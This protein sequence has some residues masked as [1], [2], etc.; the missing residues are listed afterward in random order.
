MFDLPSFQSGFAAFW[1]DARQ[2]VTAVRFARP[3]WLWLSVVPIALS[4][5]AFVAARYSRRSLA[6]LGR[7]SA[8]FALL[9]RPR[10]GRY[11]RSILLVIVWLMLVV[12]AAGP[13]WGRGADDGVAVGRDLVLVIDLSR[14]MLAEDASGPARW[15]SAVAAASDI[16]ASLRT[17]G[18]HR[19]AVVVF[20]ARPKLLVPLTT[21][22]DHL[23]N[24]I[25]ELDGKTL[26]PD[27]R[28]TAEAK[29]GTRI[30]AAIIAAVDAHDVRFPGSQDILLFSDGDDPVDDRE[31]ASGINAARQA[32]IPV[33]AIGIGD[34]DRM[35]PVT[36]N[37]QLLEYATKPGIPDPVQTRLHEEVLRAIADESRGYYVPVRREVPQLAEFFRTKIE[38]F[39]SR[40]LTDDALP[41][42]RDRAAWFLGIGVLFLVVGWLRER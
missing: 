39:P 12:G 11:F 2:F 1:V 31:W 41:Q 16:V 14:S 8:I 28:P 33:H 13:R 10:A 15:E 7:P 26:L 37:G 4:I 40:E 29:S 34:P 36:V 20:A 18:G 38:P 42:P 27:L 24:A 23:Q 5:V 25:A 22:Y 21:D 3:G 35:S 32:N 17:R 9:T 6:T 19:A 30:G